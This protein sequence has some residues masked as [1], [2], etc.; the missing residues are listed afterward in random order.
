MDK[1]SMYLMQL[2]SDEPDRHK[3]YINLLLIESIHPDRGGSRIFLTTG[4]V[5]GCQESNDTLI[6]NLSEIKI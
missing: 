5:Y 2:T 4:N 1:H 6:K 3:F